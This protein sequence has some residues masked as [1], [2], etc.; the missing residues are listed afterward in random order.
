MRSELLAIGKACHNYLS[1]RSLVIPL[2]PLQNA[3]ELMQRNL[4]LLAEYG[5]AEEGRGGSGKGRR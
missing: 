2:T 3:L 1:P 4:N 5:I